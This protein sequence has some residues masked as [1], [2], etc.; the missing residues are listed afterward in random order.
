VSSDVISARLEDQYPGRFIEDVELDR[1]EFAYGGDVPS[2]PKQVHV[3]SIFETT[4]D[5]LSGVPYRDA[6]NAELWDASGEMAPENGDKGGALKPV[7][8]T[9]IDNSASVKQRIIDDVMSRP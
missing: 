1:S 4:S 9:T 8:H 6:P 2:K 3:L 7:T 5:V